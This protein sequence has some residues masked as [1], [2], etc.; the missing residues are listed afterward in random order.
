M[1]KLLVALLALGV[2]SFAPTVEAGC[3]KKRCQPKKEC[4]TPCKKACAKTECTTKRVDKGT[5]QEKCMV[6]VP[7]VYDVTE[8]DIEEMCI[9]RK[10]CEE[11]G[12]PR[13][14]DQE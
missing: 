6:T 12:E 3:N 14:A 2:L 10:P 4:K 11:R 8:Y 1:K 9:T 5:R 7:G 13:C